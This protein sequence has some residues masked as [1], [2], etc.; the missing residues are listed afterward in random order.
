MPLVQWQDLHA[1][2][3]FFYFNQSTRTT[4]YVLT[5]RC[6]LTW[7][8][9]CMLGEQWIQFI[10]FSVICILSDTAKASHTGLRNE[11]SFSDSGKL[12]GASAERA[13]VPAILYVSSGFYLIKRLWDQL[14]PKLRCST[15]LNDY[16]SS[17]DDEQQRWRSIQGWRGNISSSAK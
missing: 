14:L 12:W 7:G 13:S 4:Y 5:C 3:N 11:L 16:D 17:S 1:V 15:F 9:Y 6:Q 8:R 2:L 10:S